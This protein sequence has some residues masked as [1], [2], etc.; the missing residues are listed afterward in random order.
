MVRTFES[1]TY[2][3]DEEK[4]IKLGLLE[5]IQRLHPNKKIYDIKFELWG[6]ELSC[7]Y[8]YDKLD[9]KG[10]STVLTESKMIELEANHG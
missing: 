3:V 4:R 7:W 2:S 10:T 9:C 1:P 6:N 8:T 5:T